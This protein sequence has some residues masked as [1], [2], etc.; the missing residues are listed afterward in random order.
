VVTSEDIASTLMTKGI[1]AKISVIEQGFTKVQLSVEKHSKFSIAYT[2]NYIHYYGDKH[3]LHS[4]WGATN[5]IEN[6]IPRVL[7]VIPN[8]EIHLFGNLGANAERALGDFQQVII[9]GFL[10][11][12]E[13]S[14]ELSR[15]HLGIYPRK[16]DNGWRV[17]KVYEYI[18]AGLPIVTYRS[19][20]TKTVE[21]LNIGI[22]VSTDEEF[23][24]AIR[25]LSVDNKLYSALTA[26]L[27]ACS[28]FF[29]WERQS[30][31]LDSL[32]I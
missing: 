32:F 29:T 2:S 3:A 26:R 28:E 1:Q 23:I 22:S 8:T 17:Q 5:L 18:G 20:D 16:I 7:N 11:P 6:I 21:E 27:K 13:H 15:C 14:R 4:G 19:S 30:K 12:D 24:N 31:K 9:H 25:E 10:T